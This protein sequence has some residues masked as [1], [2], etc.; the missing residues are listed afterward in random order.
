ME[1]TEPQKTQLYLLQC[2][3]D[4]GIQD[5]NEIGLYC[6]PFL[7]YNPRDRN[8]ASQHKALKPLIE[9]DAVKPDPQPHPKPYKYEITKRGKIVFEYLK[10]MAKTR[11]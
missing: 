9:C 8:I 4:K 3:N 2:L 11:K 10:A 1:L 7:G 6:E 5:A